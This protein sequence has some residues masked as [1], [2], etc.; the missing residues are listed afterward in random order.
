MRYDRRKNTSL[1]SVARG[2]SKR[3]RLRKELNTKCSVAK[4]L[5]EF[6]WIGENNGTKDKTI[7]TKSRVR[8]Q[9]VKTEQTDISNTKVNVRK[10][11]RNVDNRKTKI[12]KTQ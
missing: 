9:S 3:K 11:I 7:N 1:V 6:K 10:T 8:T 5:I 4:Q 2:V 12:I